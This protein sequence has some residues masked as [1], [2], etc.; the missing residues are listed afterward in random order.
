MQR[1]TTAIVLAPAVTLVLMAA[2]GR[3]H[4]DIES[5]NG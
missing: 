2:P 4:I 5:G 1:L 3:R